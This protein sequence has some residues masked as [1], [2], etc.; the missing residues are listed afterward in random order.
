MIQVTGKQPANHAATRNRPTK[1]TKRKAT[2]SVRSADQTARNLAKQH[3]VM[4]LLRSD[5]GQW[6]PAN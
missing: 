5:M 6:Q 3:V 2:Q 1:A 4:K